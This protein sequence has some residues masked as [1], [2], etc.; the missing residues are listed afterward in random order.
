MKEVSLLENLSKRSHGRI[1]DFIMKE[2]G[3]PKNV[4]LYEGDELSRNFF[5]MVK[6]DR[7]D[8][9]SAYPKKCCLKLNS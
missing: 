7:L 1:I 4:I 6:R 5:E 8:G 3:N 2:H 9:I